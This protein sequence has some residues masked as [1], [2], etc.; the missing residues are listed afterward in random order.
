MEGV[1]INDKNSESRNESKIKL[2]KNIKDSKKRIDCTLCSKNFES[3]LNF[4]KHVMVVHQEKKKNEC[5]FCPLKTGNKISL[6]NH[7]SMVHD[8]KKLCSS[9]SDTEDNKNCVECVT[10]T[11]KNLRLEI[12]NDEAKNKLEA[13]EEL[14][15]KYRKLR[16]DWAVKVYQSNPNNEDLDILLSL[17]PE[18]LFEKYEQ[19]LQFN[20]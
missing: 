14:N 17:E 16:Q 4:K 5:S 15:A 11:N 19:I 8:G 1:F 3:T 9:K 20:E 2:G 12:E 10:K 13:L 7:V 18:K 6:I